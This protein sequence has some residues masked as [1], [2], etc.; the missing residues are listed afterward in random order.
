MTDFTH[1]LAATDFSSGSIAALE[2]G[3]LIAKALGIRYS[4]IHAVD[5]G[6]VASFRRLIEEKFD[7]LSKSVEEKARKQLTQVVSDAS[8]DSGLCAELHLENGPA[9]AAVSA[10]ASESDMGLIVL[11]AQGNGFLSQP[12]VGSTVSR[13]LHTS[14]KPVLVVKRPPRDAYSR[15]LVAADF[16][17]VSEATVRLAH[18]IAPGAE[19]ILMHAFEEPIFEETLEYGDGGEQITERYRERA[20]R[21]LQQLAAAAGLSASEFSVLVIRGDAK[22]EIIANMDK[23]GCDLVVMGKHGSGVIDELLLGSVANRVLTDSQNDVLI[24]VDEREPDLWRYT[25]ERGAKAKLLQSDG[26]DI[27]AWGVGEPG[28]LQEAIGGEIG[29]AIVEALREAFA[30]ADACEFNFGA[31]LTEQDIE[32]RPTDL[33]MTLPFM[34]GGDAWEGPLLLI[35]LENIVREVIDRFDASGGSLPNPDELMKLRD[36]LRMLAN[37]INKA[38]IR[39]AAK[40]AARVEQ[41]SPLWVA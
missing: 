30:K 31:T 11:G 17:P 3:F 32:A 4:V 37:G 13:I 20:H 10:L 1:I 39:N 38:P 16:S 23:F 12:L 5:E 9:W 6:A 34:S 7:L 19:I 40:I 15:V 27:S 22:R 29:E 28:P 25:E 35:S 36:G 21:E 41:K 33:F 2:R 18:A 24:V 14:R 8:R 26:F